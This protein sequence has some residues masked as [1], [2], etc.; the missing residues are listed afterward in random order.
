[1]CGPD[2][3]VQ[4]RT[5]SHGQCIFENPLR[6]V[7][8]VHGT[9]ASN[10]DAAGLL[11]DGCEDDA[12]DA[13]GQVVCGDD[14]ACPFVIGAVGDD[15]FQLIA[16]GELID[17]AP[18]IAVCFAAAGCFEIDDADDTRVALLERAGSACFEKHCFA[19]VAELFHERVDAGLKQWLAAGDLDERAIVRADLLDDRF[20]G[21][22]LA[23]M[24]C[25]LG[26][27]IVTSEMAAGEPD[28]DARPAGPGGFALNGV[29]NLVDSQFLSRQCVSPA[30]AG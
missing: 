4:L 29:E 24:K 26:V 17:D 13:S 10:L 27:A 30:N 12:L 25:V 5:E 18:V 14:L 1:M 3:F 11:H 21:A 23:F 15:E 19:E 2:R 28:K 6:E 7:S 9:H 8:V 16:L 22:F 20:D